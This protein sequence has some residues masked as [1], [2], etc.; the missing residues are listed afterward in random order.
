MSASRPTERR[1][2]PCRSVVR[3]PG[4]EQQ[5]TSAYRRVRLPL[6]C[7]PLPKRVY[8]YLLGGGHPGAL[9]QGRGGADDSFERGDTDRIF[10]SPV[11]LDPDPAQRAEERIA[12][13]GPTPG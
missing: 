12:E 8:A 3:R 6:V 7:Q 13:N 11:R 10:G 2:L 1:S 9:D 4:T 5:G